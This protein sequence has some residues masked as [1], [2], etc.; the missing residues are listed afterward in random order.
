VAASD[1]ELM[2]SPVAAW[3]RDEAR[4]EEERTGSLSSEAVA[5]VEVAARRRPGRRRGLA[6][7]CGGQRRSEIYAAEV[8]HGVISPKVPLVVSPSST[9][10]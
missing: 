7:Q 9:E 1:L 2:T 4:R 3:W 8:A 6:R 5:A 10:E